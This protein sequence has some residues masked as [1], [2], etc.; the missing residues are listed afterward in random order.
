MP[1][2]ETNGAPVPSDPDFAARV[3]GSFARQGA[4][5]HLGAR[6]TKVAPGAV[7]IRLP[8]RS[9]V[10]QQHGFFHGGVVATIGDSAAGYAGYSLMPADASVLTVE[11]KINLV[12]PAK[13]QELVARGRVVKPGRTLTV[14]VAEIFAVEQ[15]RETLCAVMQQTLICLPGRADGPPSGQVIGE[16]GNP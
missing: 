15:G 6:L 11:Y 4:M 10:A 14:T 5:S 1:P 13:G 9:E 8:Y 3:S 7:E 12:A 16:S 2:L